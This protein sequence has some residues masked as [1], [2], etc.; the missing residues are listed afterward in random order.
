MRATKQKRRVG[1]DPL[2]A[3]RFPK[4]LTA[5]VDHWAKQRDLSRSEAVR[6]LVEHALEMFS[7]ANRG[8]RK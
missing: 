8:K 5:S 2:L 7:Q 6:R 1:H 4:E 3:V